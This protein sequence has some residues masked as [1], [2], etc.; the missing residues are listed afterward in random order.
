LRTFSNA[1]RS[2]CWSEAR[3]ERNVGRAFEHIYMQAA[4]I[5]AA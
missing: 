4:D 1:S 3:R 5:I 2:T